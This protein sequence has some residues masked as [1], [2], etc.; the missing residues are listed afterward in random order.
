MPESKFEKMLRERKPPLGL[1]KG[2]WDAYQSPVTGE[3][4]TSEAHR[5]EDL[6]KNDCVDAREL[7]PYGQEKHSDSF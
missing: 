1:S 6:K 7:L 2:N 5:Q 3:V 4:I